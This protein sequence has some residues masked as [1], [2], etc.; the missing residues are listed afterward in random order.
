MVESTVVLRAGC[1]ESHWVG[2]R[3]YWRVVPRVKRWV[4]STAGLWV[5]RMV[6]WRERLMAGLKAVTMALIW[7]V[8]WAVSWDHC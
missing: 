1:W 5:V 3:G 4:V 7:V 6:A 2:T 8:Y